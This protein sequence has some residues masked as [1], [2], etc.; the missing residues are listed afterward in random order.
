MEVVSA[1]KRKRKKKCLG[2]P[3]CNKNGHPTI[4]KVKKISFLLPLP[5]VEGMRHVL[6]RPTPHGHGSLLLLL[7]MLLLLLLAARLELIRKMLLH[8]RRVHAVIL[9]LPLLLRRAVQVA[10]R[11]GRLQG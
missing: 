7:M 1:R 9:L 4:P 8:R 11:V 10:E 2:Q 5:I 6:V 3:L